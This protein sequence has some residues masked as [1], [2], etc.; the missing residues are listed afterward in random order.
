MSRF[1]AIALVAAFL[2]AGCSGGVPG[3]PSEQSRDTFPYPRSVDELEADPSY[4]LEMTGEQSGIAYYV[5][6]VP[7]EQIEKTPLP[8]DVYER[9]LGGE[10][11]GYVYVPVRDGRIVEPDLGDLITLAF[12]LSGSE[13][14][15]ADE[16]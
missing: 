15:Q 14:P 1:R 11:E 12:R 3:G 4:R 6:A 7:Y 2:A 8:E 10:E 16:D 5:K 13:L 9:L